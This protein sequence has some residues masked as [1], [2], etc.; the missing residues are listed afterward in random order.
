MFWRSSLRLLV[1]EYSYGAA[2]F[3]CRLK[4]RLWRGLVAAIISAAATHPTAAQQSAAPDRLQ[5]RSLR[6]FLTSLSALSALPAAGELDRCVAAPATMRR[7]G[8]TLA[9][10][11]WLLQAIFGGVGFVGGRGSLA[12]ARRLGFRWLKQINS[13]TTRRCTRPPAGLSFFGL[14]G[15]TQSWS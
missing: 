14:S 5:L 15:S 2:C 11:R 9:A 1:H 13:N 3:A 4:S 7:G 10:G 12:L 8:S 6:S